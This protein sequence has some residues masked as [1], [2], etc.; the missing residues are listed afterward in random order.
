MGDVRQA[1]YIHVYKRD[2]KPGE[3]QAR[4]QFVDVVFVLNFST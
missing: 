4:G 3:P 2:P 1:A